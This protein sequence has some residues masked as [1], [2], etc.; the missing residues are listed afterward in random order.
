MA[1]FNHKP[2]EDYQQTFSQDSD[3]QESWQEDEEAWQTDDWQDDEDWVDDL[4]TESKAERRER[5]RGAMRVVAGVSDFFGVIVGT[6]C[7]LLLTALL[8]SLLNWLH[9]DIQQNFVLWQNK[10]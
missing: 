4:E 3:W 2:E 10:L 6:V 7:V 9:A 5:H 1:Y 8:I